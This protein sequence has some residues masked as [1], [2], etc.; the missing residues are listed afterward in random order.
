MTSNFFL[1]KITDNEKIKQLLEKLIRKNF[2]LQKG[3]IALSLV[4][5]QEYTNNSEKIEEKIQAIEDNDEYNNLVDIFNSDFTTIQKVV[6]Q[7]LKDY[8]DEVYGKKII[9]YSYDELNNKNENELQEI[10]ELYNE[11]EK[12][13]FEGERDFINFLMT[14]E[15]ETLNTIQSEY[16]FNSKFNSLRFSDYPN[17]LAYNFIQKIMS[18]QLLP[19]F[20]E[21]AS[22]KNDKYVNHLISETFKESINDLLDDN[23]LSHLNESEKNKLKDIL[24]GRILGKDYFS[25]ALQ[26]VIDSTMHNQRHEFEQAFLEDFGVIMQN[27]LIDEIKNAV[28]ET[29]EDYINDL[30]EKQF[31]IET[32]FTDVMKKLKEQKYVNQ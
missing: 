2:E 22:S 8:D 19:Y 28:I 14:D 13:Y 16:N 20:E 12:N 15:I 29:D 11:L 4:E 1:D 6:S 17:K 18:K 21:W 7:E 27:I 25:N 5:L 31:G 26:E 3:I 9:H 24:I 10:F 23:T 30:K 32:I